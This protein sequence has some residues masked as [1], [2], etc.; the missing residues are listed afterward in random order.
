MMRK[1]TYLD[2]TFS[3]MAPAPAVWVKKVGRDAEI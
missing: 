1:A 2:L 3:V